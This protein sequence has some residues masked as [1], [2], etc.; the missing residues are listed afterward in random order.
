[1]GGLGLMGYPNGFFPLG[2][3]G[4]SEA[5]ALGGATVGGVGS[6]GSPTTKEAI[7]ARQRNGRS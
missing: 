2:L 1:M 5:V 6:H 3:N 4:A 7:Y